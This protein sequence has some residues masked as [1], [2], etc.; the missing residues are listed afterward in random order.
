[1]LIKHV[2]SRLFGLAI[3]LSL[4]TT[5]WG[6]NLFELPRREWSAGNWPWSLV[7]ADVNGDGI[8][9]VLVVNQCGNDPYCSANSTVGV[10][11]G[12]GDVTFRTDQAYDSGGYYALSVAVGDVNGDSKPDLLV[13]NQCVSSG[14]CDHGTLG[15]LLGNGDGTF[16]TVRTYDSAGSLAI[17][18]AVGDVDGD[19]KLDA[20]VANYC[21]PA[22]D[23]QTGS[24]D[25]LHGNGDGTFQAAQNHSSGGANTWAVVVKDV[26]D[27]GKLDVLLANSGEALGVA[28]LLGN[29][30]G[31]FQTARSYGATHV[32]RSIAVEDVNEDAKLDLLVANEC[33]ESTSCEHGTVS[34][35]LGKGDGTF[36]T[37]TSYD[38]GGLQ[39]YSIAAGDVNGDHKP[40]V[41][42]TNKCAGTRTYKNCSHGEVSVLLGGGDG[43]FGLQGTYPSGG[44]RASSIALADLDG[45]TRLD[46]IVANSNPIVILRNHCPRPT[47][48]ALVT[49]I[50]PSTFGQAVAITAKVSWDGPGAP[51]G[52]VTFQIG[53][54]W[55]NVKLSDGT[56]TLTTT[57]LPGGGVWIDARFN[58]DNPIHAEFAPSRSF[59]I[60][61]VNPVSSA[62]SVRSSTNRSVAGQPVTFIANVT[63]PVWGGQGSVTFT[64]GAITLGTVS[65]FWGGKA[66]ITTT[67]LPKGRHI[68]K[69]AY[70][71][72]QNIIGSRAWL[73]QTVN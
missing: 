58:G 3:L 2:M 45:D 51:Y 69:A 43:T 55:K 64:T 17:S 73:T 37:S 32:A 19:G 26:N 23:C 38:S 39:T 66:S 10:M 47:T 24:V 72:T 25:V 40:D 5:S 35:L 65:P 9:D 60:Q 52:T 1:M 42:V 41:V 30:D 71:G 16:Q 7:A 21:L 22:G 36:L 54:W 4:T 53:R 13:A 20:L 67:A 63:S 68:I 57:K 49:N 11:L 27:D 61:T 14:V 48:T 59:F 29:G 46:A 34:V 50:N 15:V 33:D 70:S 31:T 8:P 44:R 56:A 6:A 12:N 62:T 28:V 18:V